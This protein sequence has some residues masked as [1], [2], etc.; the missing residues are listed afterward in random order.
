MYCRKDTEYSLEKVLLT[1]KGGPGRSALEGWGRLFLTRRV[2]LTSRWR[3]RSNAP[4]LGVASGQAFVIE[5][6]RALTTALIEAYSML[7]SVPAP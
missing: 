3:V 2:G 6:F 7:V 1:K 4:Y 5:R